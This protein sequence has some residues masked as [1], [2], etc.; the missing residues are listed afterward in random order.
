MW[1]GQCSLWSPVPLQWWALAT[2]GQKERGG[3]ALVAADG[4]CR[5]RAM[6]SGHWASWHR[7]PR[8]YCSSKSRTIIVLGRPAACSGGPCAQKEDRGA[9]EHLQCCSAQQWDRG[10]V[11]AV[12]TAAT[13]RCALPHSGCP[14]AVEPLHDVSRLKPLP[15]EAIS[16][17][18]SGGTT[19]RK[20]P[21]DAPPI[22]H[23]TWPVPS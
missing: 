11:M 5:A 6:D 22:E 10:V 19:A 4:G 9:W 2:L 8:S 7:A 1:E 12:N 18:S 15:P 17:G 16:R 20:V 14:S 21:E 23:S 3:S 13:A